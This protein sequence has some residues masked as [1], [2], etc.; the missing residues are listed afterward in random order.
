MLLDPVLSIA[1]FPF[2]REVPR[3]SAGQVAGYL[4]YLGAVFALAST[5]ALYLHLGPLISQTA[6]WAASSMPTLTI[7][8]GRIQS[9][10]PG[11]T[12]VRH[13][14][15]SQ[16]A[17]MIDASRTTAVTPAEMKEAQLAVYLTQ[18]AIYLSLPQKQEVFDL[19]QARQQPKPLVVD[20]A[21]W[22]TLGSTLRRVLYPVSFAATWVIFVAWKLLASAFYSL[23]AL[24]LNS[25]SSAGLEYPSL[26]KLSL[27]AQTPAVALQ[28]A[29]LFL[30]RPVPYFGLI[31]LL[32]TGVYLWQ[33]IRQHTAAAA[34]G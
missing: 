17:V 23:F 15:V 12:L 6:E 2:Y 1:H 4:A 32:V 16:I 11:P 8:E 25:L 28:L 14:E 31:T 9:D 18:N 13:P 10:R 21:F 20:A 22:R 3:K 5:V 19:S 24:L 29:A 27:Y 34:A 7:S 30:P 33:G 26:Y